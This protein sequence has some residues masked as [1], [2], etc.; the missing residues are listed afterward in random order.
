MRL[1]ASISALTTFTLL[2]M[3]WAS[4]A[5]ASAAQDPLSPLGGGLDERV[6]FEMAVTALDSGERHLASEILG[7]LK[8]RADG[9]RG[10]YYSVLL[11]IAAGRAEEAREALER[12]FSEAGGTS[13]PAWI[14]TDLIHRLAE[15]RLSDRRRENSRRGEQVLARH[16]DARGGLEH[17]RS[18]ADMVVTGEI[19]SQGVVLPF[20]L[21][22]KRPL[23]YR[24]DVLT[25]EGPIIEA[26]DGTI[27]W[28][29]HPPFRLEDGTFLDGEEGAQL[30]A[31]AHF[32]DLLLRSWDEGT[33]LYWV[34]GG[35]AEPN[36]DR[37]EME[38]AEG[39]QTVF[40]DRE[41][42]LDIRRL[43]WSDK[44]EL[45]SETTT[46]HEFLDG[47]PLPAHRVSKSGSE[48][49]EYVFQSYDFDSMVD[50]ATFDLESVRQIETARAE[51]A[52][53]E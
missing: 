43:V 19:R 6:A 45:V 8:D 16:F 18:L 39:R 38:S 4:L 23:F 7:Q 25:S 3:G 44:G 28:R 11:S 9:A 12:I 10:R 47:R 46:E 42:G 26:T 52:A 49:V 33:M 22:R 35:E 17:L 13:L 2:S 21:I 36:T 30:A 31:N 27:S 50:P 53:A 5:A 32:D 48:V 15:A 51:R 40:L 41:S 37:L 20:R 1:A 24:L 14:R 29:L 34:D